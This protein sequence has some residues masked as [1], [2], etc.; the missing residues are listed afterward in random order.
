MDST[1]KALK[2]VAI[3][4][5]VIVILSLA[6]YYLFTSEKFFGLFCRENVRLRVN[7][8]DEAVIRDD[9]EWLNAP[10]GICFLQ[11]YRV[12]DV[13]FIDASDG[14]VVVPGKLGT[15][16]WDASEKKDGSVRCYY[17]VSGD[18]RI[19]YVAFGSP[20][21]GLHTPDSF[22]FGDK[23]DIGEKLMSVR[24]IEGLNLL[25]T[26][27]TKSFRG[28]FYGFSKLEHLDLSSFDTSNVTDMSDMFHYC[29]SLKELDLSSFDTSNVTDVT[30]MFACMPR[31]GSVFTNLKLGTFDLSN[32]SVGLDSMFRNRHIAKLTIGDGIYPF[33][34]Y[35]PDIYGRWISEE[36]SEKTYTTAEMVYAE[37][38]TYCASS[39]FDVVDGEF[40][41][42]AY[43]DLT[44]NPE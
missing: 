13:A 28:M 35:I 21:G 4:L 19:L 10:L 15:F 41:M 6:A 34:N 9:C 18:E 16:S 23:E 25:D 5:L 1:K 11:S 39:F 3:I 8:A 2:I 30:D 43:V 40:V 14:E 37:A 29:Y 33:W 27:K 24:S 20:D 7:L 32:V 31:F 42:K 12:T 22:A 38:G 44:S 26:S 36:N 17:V